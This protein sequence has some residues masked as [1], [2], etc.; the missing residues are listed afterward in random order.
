MKQQ[1]KRPLQMKRM[2]RQMLDRPIKVI[3]NAD[4]FGYSP[5]V[6]SG[7]LYAHQFGLVTSTTVM[8]NTQFAKQGIEMAE[9]FP[10]LGMGLHF[11][12]DI[13]RPVSSPAHSLIDHNTGDFLTGE[14]LIQSATKND[15]KKELETQLN[16]LYEWGVNVTHIDSHHHMHTHI[17]AA[18][19]A[20]IEIARQYKL[21]IRSLDRSVTE[22]DILTNN[23]FIKNFYGEGNILPSSFLQILTNLKTGVTEI[24]THPAFMDVWLKNGSSYSLPRMKELETLVDTEV[25]AYVKNHNI[26]L[27]HYGHMK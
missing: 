27:I 26:D 8:V 22:K 6:S 24:M 10:N 1:L 14:A 18:K 17:P 12:L 19:E 15:I 2:F 21:P 9:G 13:G 16:K 25:Q 3:I 7:I 5:G 20:V 11:V 4:D 23:Y